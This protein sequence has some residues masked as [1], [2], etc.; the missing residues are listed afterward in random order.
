MS[1]KYC[2][3]CR[4]LFPRNS[5][6]LTEL[7][8]SAGGSNVTAEAARRPGSSHNREAKQ[9]N[10]LIVLQLDPLIRENRNVSKLGGDGDQNIIRTFYRISERLESIELYMKFPQEYR[11]QL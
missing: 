10:V 5:L 7:H 2:F 9:T 6:L 1:K 11:Q 4:F 8:S 3:G